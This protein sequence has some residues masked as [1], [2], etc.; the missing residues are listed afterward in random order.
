[1]PWVF[2][3]GSLAG[4]G[5]RP[6]TLRGHRRTWGV[7]MD[8]TVDLPGYK[9][10]LDPVTGERP[11]VRVAFLDIEEDPARE[12]N[13]VAL[14][15]EESALPA[16]DARERNYRR[17]D[18]TSL[19]APPLDGPVWTY[20]GLEASRARAHTG[21]CV[22]SRDY[23][24]SVR[25]SFA[26]RG[27]QELAAFERSTASPPGPV[28]ALRRVDHPPLTP[29][30]IWARE[31]L[32]TLLAQRFTPRAVASFLIASQQRAN[33]V[34]RT[35]PELGSQAR[36]WT[37]LGAAAWAVPAATGVE[38]FR[39]RARS[40]L[41]WWAAC[42]LML[43]WHLGMVETAAG[44]PRPLGAADAVTLSRVWLA[45]VAADDPAP[46]VCALAAASDVLDG[47]LARRAGSTRIGRDL[48]GL[49]DFCF[50]VGA[51]RGARRRDLVSRWVVGAELARLGAG[52]AY[53]S[54]VYFGRAQAPD[55]RLLRAARLTSPVR[56]AGL[57]AAGLG[58][59]RMADGLLAGGA[60]VSL[61]ATGR[62]WKSG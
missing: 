41:G 21:P 24:E 50:A 22:I 33:A 18:V 7:A 57:I 6:C 35:R 16:L 36:R 8:N 31:Q 40:G 58:R 27:E 55:P 13:G 56:A 30:E 29:G 49:A 10:Y 34:R 20:A 26:G 62:A 1:M 17:V 5:A 60:L 19:V 59:R 28:R 48:E 15:V 32:A 12:V 54:G 46:L 47:R 14:W 39:R 25:A 37:A 4:P 38:P 61:G 44:R 3:Y 9:H 23:L 52:F 2:A 43:D 42:G 53:A 51:L 45:P 11:A